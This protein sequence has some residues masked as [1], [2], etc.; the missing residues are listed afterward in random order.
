MVRTCVC[1]ERYIL[2][3]KAATPAAGGGGS[4]A[5]VI[6]GSLRR[7]DFAVEAPFGLGRRRIEDMQFVLVQYQRQC[8]D[9]E[10]AR[11]MVDS[12]Q[13]LVLLWVLV[14]PR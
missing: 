9:M 13:L 2:P 3:G 1:C 12:L 7:L 11:S 4:P 8:R 5:T 6:S 14:D 10:P